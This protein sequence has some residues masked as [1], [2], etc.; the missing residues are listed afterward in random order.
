MKI[1]PLTINGSSISVRE[2]KAVHDVGLKLMGEFAKAALKKP[3]DRMVTE[4]T[5]M[6]TSPGNNAFPGFVDMVIRGFIPPK[7][8]GFFTNPQA[9]EEYV[10]VTRDGITG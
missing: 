6:L 10:K 1:I 3:K 4:A 2:Y 9:T 7:L 5:L 8:R